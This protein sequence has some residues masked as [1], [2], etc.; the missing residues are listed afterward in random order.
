M[1]GQGNLVRVQMLNV[2]RRQKRVNTLGFDHL[3]IGHTANEIRLRCR[4]YVEAQ[5]LPIRTGEGCG[6]VFFSRSAAAYVKKYL[7]HLSSPSRFSANHD[8]AS[9]R[10]YIASNAYITNPPWGPDVFAR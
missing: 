2:V 3:H 10:P 4:I 7:V 5:F 1:E 6:S 9:Q 8:A